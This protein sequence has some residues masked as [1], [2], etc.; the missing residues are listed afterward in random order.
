ME[1]L[2]YLARHGGEVVSNDDLIREV[3]HGRAFGDGVVYKKINQL[4]KA[5]GDD[6]RN[7]RLIETIPKRGYRLVAPVTALAPTG[8]ARRRG[9]TTEE[10][11]QGRSGPLGRR[12]SD[13]SIAPRSRLRRLAFAGAGLALVGALGTYH[14]ATIG[15]PSSADFRIFEDSGGGV[16]AAKAIGVL[17]CDD[18]SP[19]AT[20]AALAPGIYLELI[21]R[22]NKIPDV[23]VFSSR[24]LG[25]SFSMQQVASQL[26]VPWIIT[27]SV[28]H[29]GDRVRIGAQLFDGATGE[30]QW[31][32]MYPRNFADVFAIQADIAK[33]IAHELQIELS[34]TE[35]AEID[36]RPTES[37]EAYASYLKALNSGFGAQTLEYID[38]AIALDPELARAHGWRAL[39]YALSL[40]NTNPD[41]SALP[42]GHR[43]G[44]ERR[45]LESARRALELDS[46]EPFAWTARAY[47]HL[48]AWRWQEAREAYETLLEMRPSDPDA[49]SGYTWFLSFVGRHDEAQRL[50]R[51]RIE[52]DPSPN[53]YHSLGMVS[54][55]AADP[56]TTL[57]AYRTQIQSPAVQPHL[58]VGQA[59]IQLGDYAAAEQSLRTAEK[60][61]RNIS[62]AVFAHS[63][64]DLAWSYGTIGLEDKARK[65]FEELKLWSSDHDVGTGEWALASLGFDHDLAYRW[66]S[67][68]ARKADANETDMG[69]FNL[70]TIKANPFGDPALEQSRFQ[71]LRDRLGPDGTSARS[72]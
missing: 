31:S 13:Q 65:L 26:E 11:R 17:P 62:G 44:Y 32:G 8:D 40:A 37:P 23:R 29:A 39:V 57:M 14:L 2:V 49:L 43:D 69:F 53:A 71:A 66:L 33:S 6:S 36:K 16:V 38:E 60:L 51:R 50:A 41:A 7:A 46:G 55:W 25:N 18:L 24:F 61:A 1:L 54:F 68:A 70:M 22:L 10:P 58:R 35:L 52:L 67:Q 34:V 21:N 20:D 48:L 27:C 47:T 30:V 4:R 3:W 56:K 5:L 15:R 45:A 59:Q 9:D 12:E 19:S 72:D 28:R 42:R 64:A 63:I